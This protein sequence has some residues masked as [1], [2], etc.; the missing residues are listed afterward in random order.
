MYLYM[1]KL[2]FRYFLYINFIFSFL[3]FCEKNSCKKKKSCKNYLDK[4][5]KSW[6]NSKMFRKNIK[7]SKSLDPPSTHTTILVLLQPSLFNEALL[8]SIYEVYRHADF[9]LLVN[10]TEIC[11][12]CNSVEKWASKL[13]VA[14]IKRLGIPAKP[15][16]PVSLTSPDRIKLTLQ[17][18][19]LKCVQLQKKID[20]MATELK[21]LSFS[22][23]HELSGDLIQTFSKADRSNVTDFIKL[24]WQQQQKLFSSSVK[25]VRFHPLII[26]FCLSLAVNSALVMRN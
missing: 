22:V 17:D 8:F 4:Q 25:C 3:D 21:K 9:A 1:I 16:A 10:K 15:K 5:E 7:I 19:R 2:T 20:D 18:Q 23:D 14:K 26:R 11:E 24:F 13:S 12:I 6:K